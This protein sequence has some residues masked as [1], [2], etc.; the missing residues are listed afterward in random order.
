M[1]LIQKPVVYD[2]PARRRDTSQFVGPK[3][4]TTPYD[5]I[6]RI[7]N[8]WTVEVFVIYYHDMLQFEY[9]NPSVPPIGI[10][11]PDFS[12]YHMVVFDFLAN[13]DRFLLPL[14]E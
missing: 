6:R 4:A 13:K 2:E 8:I 7:Y 1:E 11:D 10:P 14:R 9:C 5:H 3:Y 12:P